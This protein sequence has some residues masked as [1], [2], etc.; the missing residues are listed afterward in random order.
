MTGFC[1]KQ[2]Q[3]VKRS[4]NIS[5]QEIHQDHWHFTCTSANVIYCITCTYGNELYIGETGRRLGNRFREHLCDV[6]IN[7]KD[8]SKPVV[9]HFHLP[10]HSKQDM[11][12]CG[13][14][15]H[16]GSS[17]SRK[18]QNKNLSSKSIFLIPTVSTSA[19]IQLILL[20]FSSPNS[21]NS[22]APPSAYKPTHN[23]QFLQS[24]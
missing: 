16:L 12:V 21:P 1:P 15:L 10:N 3:G 2:D 13:L 6:E 4:E 5:T 18:T 11:A 7:D 8:A 19:F 24:L 14:S 22:V 23:P 9:R 20:V 17:E